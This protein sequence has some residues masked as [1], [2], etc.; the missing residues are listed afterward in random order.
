ML[1]SDSKMEENSKQHVVL[2]ADLSVYPQHEVFLMQEHPPH[3][4]HCSF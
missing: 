2:K 4:L 1:Q 3:C